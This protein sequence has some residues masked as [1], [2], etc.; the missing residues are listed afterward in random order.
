MA[1]LHSKLQ[2]ST[3]FQE[4]GLK[5]SVLF[6]DKWSSTYVFF[7]NSNIIFLYFGKHMGIIFPNAH[8]FHEIL[9]NSKIVPPPPP[10]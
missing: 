9:D 10:T 3:F 7:E 2:K 8:D 6:I 1:V 5:F 4:I